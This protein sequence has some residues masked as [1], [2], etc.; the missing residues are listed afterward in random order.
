M[1][2]LI[3]NWYSFRAEV[4]RNVSKHSKTCKVAIEMEVL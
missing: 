4:L 2:S 1:A 3:C